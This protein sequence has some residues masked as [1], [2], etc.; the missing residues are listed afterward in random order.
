MQENIKNALEEWNFDIAQNIYKKNLDGQAREYVDFLY[1]IGDVDE[2][3]LL[4]KNSPQNQWNDMCFGDFFEFYDFLMTIKTFDDEKIIDCIKQEKYTPLCINYIVSQWISNFCLK[5]ESVVTLLP[6]VI[7]NNSFII[8]QSFFIKRVVDYFSCMTKD[9]FC[10]ET[11][12]I[13]TILQQNFHTNMVAGGRVY[14]EKFLLNYNANTF[15]NQYLK[16]SKKVALCIG[17]AMRGQEWELNLKKVIESFPFDVDVFLF[18]WDALFLWPGLNGGGGFWSRRLVSTDLQSSI[19]QEIM[20]KE[21]LKQHFPNVFSKL[22]QE[23]FVKLDVEKLRNMDIKRVI[24]ENNEHFTENYHLDRDKP[25]INT[26]KI[27]YSNYQLLKS[28]IQHEVENNFQYDFIIRVRPDVEYDINFSIDELDKL[29]IND[30][31]IKH[32]VGLCAGL[33]DNFAAGRRGAMEIYLS[34]WKYG[35]LNKSID[36]YKDFPIFHSAHDF[37]QQFCSLMKINCMCLRRHTIKN[38]HLVN[39]MP[40]NFSKELRMDCERIKSNAE[41]KKRLSSIGFLLKYEE[42]AKKAKA[43]DSLPYKLGVILIHNSKTFT[44]ILRI[45]TQILVCLRR[46]RCQGGLVS[47]DYNHSQSKTIKQTFTYKLGK[48]LIQAHKTWY[49]GGYIKFWFDWYQLRKELKNKK[50]KKHGNR[51]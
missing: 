18:T 13:P 3:I 49:K 44:G 50:G 10:R 11:R 34:I 38:F 47:Q 23:Y 31:M 7:K 45:P 25:F 6:Y 30:I 12:N 39:F 2:L 51:I 36:F 14:Y 20:H 15:P 16:S 28:V 37:L 26:S 8:F 29:Q 32:H 40:P 48:A 46:H 35:F 9:F 43:Y 1:Q 24:I 17:G 42:Y 33:N 19:P 5:K 4:L 22:N 27:W 41:M 21:G